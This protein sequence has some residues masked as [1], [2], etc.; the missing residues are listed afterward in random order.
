M[1]KYN[2]YNVEGNINF[3]EEYLDPSKY[4]LEII[5]KDICNKIIYSFKK[6]RKIYG[7]YFICCI[8]NYLNIIS[9]QINKLVESGLYDA[10]DSI[11]C[12]VCLKTEECINYLKKYEKIKIISTSENLYE[13]Y[14]INNFKKYL[15][16]DYYLYYIHSKSVTHNE[17]NF[18]DWRNLCDYFTITKW[19]LS[20]EF[21]NY[22]DC[23]GINL[24]NFPK[25]HFSC[26]FWWSKSEH[27]NT[28]KDIN[29]GYLS[30]EMYICSNLRTNYVCIFNSNICHYFYNF[31]KELYNTI[32]DYNII[33][34]STIIPTF[35]LSDKGS[36]R[37][38]I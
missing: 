23:V 8:D 15:S 28:L 21:L 6:L 13:K 34:N 20:I 19:R 30:P 24:Y 5:K 3:Y 17:S 26:N 29:N 14:A 36:I 37:R 18:I 16:G 22:Y 33:N 10:S 9:E 35:N 31:P 25:R 38:C 1:I 27:L 11:L 2:N 32:T 4:N 12:F 7:I